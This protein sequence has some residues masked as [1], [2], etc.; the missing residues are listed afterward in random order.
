LSCWFEFHLLEAG[1]EADLFIYKITKGDFHLQ[2]T[3][4]GVDVSGPTGV[5]GS[6]DLIHFVW[7]NFETSYHKRY[8][9]TVILSDITDGN[10]TLLFHKHYRAGTPGW[11]DNSGL[12]CAFLSFAMPQ[13][14]RPIASYLA[15]ARVMFVSVKYQNYLIWPYAYIQ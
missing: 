13:G 11:K 7:N 8:A 2:V 9:I 12:P 1:P 3:I 14:N 10:P 15:H 6:V 4:F 5:H